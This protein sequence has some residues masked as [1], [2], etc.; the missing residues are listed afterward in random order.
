M[1]R[2]ERK[3]IKWGLV[4]GAIAGLIPVLYIS[5]LFVWGTSVAGPRPV[6]ETRP[7]PPLV[8][9]ALWARANGGAAT[10]L[11]PI[12]PIAMARHVMCLELDRPESNTPEARDLHAIECAKYMPALGGIE[13]LAA[14]H[15][16]DQNVQRA[17]FRGGAGALATTVW[18]T[19][20]WT[21]EEFVNTLAARADYGNGWRG[22]EAAAQGYFGRAPGELTLPQAALL[23]SRISNLEVDPWCHPVGTTARRDS[24]L[25]KMRAGNAI[26]E[27][28]FQQALRHPLDLAPAPAGRPPCKE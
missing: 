21:R 17:S 4:A 10:A 26:D 25:R 8:Q 20:S 14:L 27:Q 22:L 16:Q 9:A 23:A 1:R 3:F 6:A 11:R 28:A 2:E 12:N 24:V 7:A 13:H 5:F 18:M 15:L 19:R